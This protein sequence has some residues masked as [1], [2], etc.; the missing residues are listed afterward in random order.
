VI[1]GEKETGVTLFHLS[2]GVDDGDI[3]GQRKFPIG[4][5]ET[6]DSLVRR[7][8]TAATELVAETLPLIASNRAPRTVQNLGEAFVVPQRSPEDGRIDWN[9]KAHDLFNFIRA[10]TRPYPGAFFD[11]KGTPIRVWSCRPVESRHGVFPGEVLRTDPDLLIKT[12]GEE[13]LLLLTLG[14]PM[15]DYDGAS[16]ANIFAVVSGER[17]G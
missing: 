5:E 10:Q 6:I 7:A 17:L 9:Q 11:Y 4:E 14:T 2:E 15:G 12:A 16:F 3:I 8:E 1:R 13:A